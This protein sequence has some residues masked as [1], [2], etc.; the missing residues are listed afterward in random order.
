MER[1]LTTVELLQQRQSIPSHVTESSFQSLPAENVYTAKTVTYLLQDISSNQSTRK[2]KR[3]G[4]HEYE[5]LDQPL[6]N[7]RPKSFRMSSPTSVRSKYTLSP[8]QLPRPTTK[9]SLVGFQS[10]ICLI[11]VPSKMG[12]SSQRRDGIRKEGYHITL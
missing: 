8:Q 12:T 2:R 7:Q 10:F 3:Y 1:P 6:E 4:G 9:C 11:V 5:E